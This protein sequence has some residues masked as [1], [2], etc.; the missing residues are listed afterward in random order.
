MLSKQDKL[1]QKNQPKTEV[2]EQQWLATLSPEQESLLLHN[3]STIQRLPSGVLSSDISRATHSVHWDAITERLRDIY[4]LGRLFENFQ[5]SG[6]MERYKTEATTV[7]PSGLLA[8][9]LNNCANR[10][11]QPC[12]SYVSLCLVC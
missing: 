8:V 4:N 11:R 3:Q 2:V 7:T 9:S 1:Q 6:L 12:K 10:S 5:A